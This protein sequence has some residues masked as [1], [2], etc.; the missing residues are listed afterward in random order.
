MPRYNYVCMS[1]GFQFE[2][3]MSYEHRKEAECPDCG[4]ETDIEYKDF[5]S[6]TEV[7]ETVN[8]DKNKKVI[9]GVK[10]TLR[11]RSNKHKLTTKES[12]TFME[13]HGAKEAIKRGYFDK[14]R[15]KCI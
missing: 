9:R 5:G 8:K 13:K 10:E 2:Q 15:K 11:D 1:C 3:N 7:Y 12:S 14:D 4:G 6:S